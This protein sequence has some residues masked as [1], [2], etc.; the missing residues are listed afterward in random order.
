MTAETTRYVSW[1]S[2]KPAVEGREEEIVNALGIPWAAG[3]RTH[4]D[5]PYPAHHGK[6]DWRLNT[7]GR[8]ICTCT[9]GKTD[10][11]F[12]IAMKVEGL[13][14]EQAKIRCME[15][16]GRTDLI[17]EKTE[18]GQY[19]ATDA[20]SLLKAPADRRDDTLPRAYLGHRLGVEAATVPMPSTPVV[21]FKALAY[22]DPPKGKGKP[23]KAGEWPCAVFGQINAAG[24][25]HAHRI[26]VEAGGAGKADLGRSASNGT[27]RDPKKSAKRVGEE[28]TAGRAVIWGNPK[29]APWCIIAEGIETAAAVAYAFRQEIET[30]ALYVAAGVNAGG[31]EVFEPWA[32][33]RRVTVAADR[34]EAAKITRP[35]P[36]R[37]GEQ[38]ARTFGIRNRERVT[39]A[40]A[41]AGA[42][43]S[44][45]DW[46][47]VHVAHGT[48]A[49]RTG[50]LGAVAY[51]PTEEEVEAERQRVEGL[52]HLAR[53]ERDYP[54]PDLDTFS[55]TYRHTASGRVKVHKW[56]KDEE[57][58]LVP[59]PIATP[60][61]VPARLHYLDR[62]GAYGLRITVEDMGG[63][64][65]E[66]DVTRS[67]F[68]KQ[69]A[70][71]TRAM[72]FAAGLRAEDD[73]DII[74]VKVLKA[75]DPETEI[76][77][78]STPGWHS[79]DGSTDRF[80]VCPS[81]E[82]IGTPEGRT[83]E[84]SIGSRI[85]EAVARGG[86]MEGWQAAVSA[87]ADVARCPHWTLGAIAGFAAALVALTGLDTCGVNLSGTTSGGKTT[88]QRLA[89]SAWSQAALDRRDSLLQSARATANG[90]EGMAARA[91]GTILA[92]DELGHVTGKEL[93]KNIYS[94]ASG[95]GKSRMTADAQLRAS[96]TWS[97]FVVLSAEKSL[98]EK[99]RGDG[100]E[101]YGGM[102]ARI[103]DVDVTNVDRAVD[104]AVMAR[105]QAC[106]QHFG[107]AGPAFVRE[108]IARG[109][110]LRAEEIRQ[111]INQTADALAGPGADSAMRRAA[112]PFA[113]LMNAGRMACS[114]GILPANVDV[115]TA[116]DWA[117]GKFGVSTD[118]AA[119][120]PEAQAVNNLRT[121]VAE[122]WDSEVHPTEIEIGTKPPSRNALAWYDDAVVYI[123][124]KRI[125]E[126]AGGTL[127]ETE[128]G[129]A[130]SAQ[131]L[132]A[133]RKDK[134]C[135]FHTF[136]PKV[137]RF[138]VY[139]LRR[140]EFRMAGREELAFTVH[141]GG[142]R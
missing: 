123:P 59:S 73:G 130:L 2:A 108:I 92:L 125:V 47:D 24:L 56:V 68:A 38:A 96:H 78:V 76:A 140:A 58:E 86:T 61:G 63:R 17:R 20:E 34:D 18:G 21:G 115:K 8:A 48:D 15:I 104:Q 90:I 127:K 7:K 97:T 81:G 42:P 45:T 109:L 39:V 99:V 134:D 41:L 102:A 28:S 12:D 22:F 44:S 119:L 85:S 54:L 40:I 37:R 124:A 118:A 19:Q 88:A 117:W 51:K 141:A 66:I 36:S 72:L 142:R 79:L 5:C 84:L 46:L 32:A 89:V 110:H 57:G 23:T 50:I 136:V 133:K 65:R 62:A 64:R 111:G 137:G 93:G 35:E 11:V 31:V 105:I 77:V 107:H 49:V 129:R 91:N 131:D 112:L 139:A 83:L 26:W 100:G 25:Q 82:V 69:G 98:E 70:A 126:A 52:D 60:F 135:N 27:V 113:V 80:F 67:D 138:K 55:L 120:D 53:V 3:Q 14:E 6:S 4:I 106:D 87:A 30:G 74:A 132:I 95:V 16:I 43:G 13:D 121:W 10:S 128:I 114:F 101:W 122:R 29:V 103:P 94:L 1:K 116:V 33:T 75:A 71:E 9:D